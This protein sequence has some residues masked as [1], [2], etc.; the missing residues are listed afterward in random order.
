MP[1]IDNL[2]RRVVNNRRRQP[3]KH[4][5]FDVVV[6]SERGMILFRGKTV[7]ISQSGARLAGLPTDM[8]LCEGDRILVEITVPP[9]GGSVSIRRITTVGRVIR[10]EESPDIFAVGVRFEHGIHL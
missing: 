5:V 4:R 6:R 2:L 8:G 10:V 9:R 1:A 7:N 3:R